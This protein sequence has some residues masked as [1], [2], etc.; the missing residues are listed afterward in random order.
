VVSELALRRLRFSVGFRAGPLLP[1][2]VG[3]AAAPQNAGKRFLANAPSNRI[4][5]AVWITLAAGAWLLW[6]PLG[7]FLIVM[8]IGN[9]RP[10]VQRNAI[11]WEKPKYALIFGG[12]AGFGAAAL[13]QAVARFSFHSPYSV[14]G[15]SVLGLFAVGYIGYGIPTDPIFQDRAQQL[16]LGAKGAAVST[17]LL[18]TILV[19]VWA[20]THGWYQPSP[21]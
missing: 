21:P 10:L 14:V 20:F 11:F 9:L 15:I 8:S 3:K 18:S 6:H 12:L 13:V 7:A 1:R 4:L 5:A 17:Y 2:I 16:E 19:L